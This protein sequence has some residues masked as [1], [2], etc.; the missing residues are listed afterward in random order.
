MLTNVPMFLY[1]LLCLQY[2]PKTVASDWFTISTSG[3]SFRGFPLWMA[4][5]A[6]CEL[7][8][9]IKFDIRVHNFPFLLNLSSMRENSAS[10]STCKAPPQ[11]FPEAGF[12]NATWIPSADATGINGS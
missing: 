11:P 12:R 8:H 10:K 1:S 5:L 6:K 7:Q 3:H 2:R 9:N 4:T